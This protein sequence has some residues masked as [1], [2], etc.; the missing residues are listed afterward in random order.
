MIWTSSA[1]SHVSSWPPSLLRLNSSLVVKSG[2]I[3]ATA[4]ERDPSQ[5]SIPN[6]GVQVE[7]G[8]AAL[9]AGDACCEVG[10]AWE[11]GSAAAPSTG[12]TGPEPFS[13]WIAA[14]KAPPAE[15]LPALSFF[16]RD[17]EQLCF[18]SAFDPLRTR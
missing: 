15:E 3:P 17:F 1:A 5:A 16:R 7:A 6:S 2:C 13:R 4:V 9:V 10:G 18:L 8:R 14:S 11:A 12:P